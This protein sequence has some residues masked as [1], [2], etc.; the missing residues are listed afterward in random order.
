MNEKTT[1]PDM[2]Q[3]PT[4]PSITTKPTERDLIAEVQET[5]AEV[6]AA[7]PR[8]ERAAH[9]RELVSSL[10]RATSAAKRLAALTPEEEEPEDDED[11]NEEPLTE[12]GPG[13][14]PALALR[15][16]G[17]VLLNPEYLEG[18]NLE[19]RERWTGVVLSLAESCDALDALNGAACD[20]G[21]HIGGRALA[22]K[23]AKDEGGEGGDAGE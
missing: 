22:K 8:V 9:V 10:E 2:G 19:G 23:K 7:M 12:P 17:A 3:D 1:R 13:P 5:L 18:A 16:D 11:E 15:S 4:D 14:T 6:D 21:A 20:A